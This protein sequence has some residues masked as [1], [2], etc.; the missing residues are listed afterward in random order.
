MSI[1][2]LIFSLI[3]ISIVV[4]KNPIVYEISI[5]PWLYELSIKYGRSITKLEDIPEE[6]I[7]F[8]ADMGVDAVYIMGIWKLGEYGLNY[9]KTL[10][11]DY[12]LP[13]WQEEDI[14]GSPFAITEYVCNPELGTDKDIQVL[15][16]KFNIRQVKLYLDFVPNHSAI[17][18][19]KTSTDEDM[20]IMAP[21]GKENLT[22]RYAEN[23]LAYGADYAH[24]AWVDVNQWNYFE[25]KTIT[26]MMNNL[27]KVLTY[28]DGVVCT[29]AYLEINDVFE[30]TW[31]DELTYF[32]YTKPEEEF[33]TIAI[34]NARKNFK[35]AVFIAEAYT[36]THKEKLLE[37]GFDYVLDADLRSKL[38]YSAN[39]VNTYIQQGSIIPWEKTAHFIENHDTERF[40]SSVDGDYEK[41]K[42]AGTIAASVGGMVFMNH[43]QWYGRK[44]KLDIHLRR[45]AG[46]D[47]NNDMLSYYKQLLPIL[48]NTAFKSPQYNYVETDNSDFVAY[49]REDESTDNHLLVV[50]NYSDTAK[51]GNVPIYNIKGLKYCLLYE[52]FSDEEYVR[53]V[54]LIK[55]NGLQVCLK[56]WETQIFKYNY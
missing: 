45:A 5:R 33:W 28:S 2:K 51:C 21:P 8:I 47:N 12:V 22:N 46:E 4:T 23:G 54:E 40:V 25:P 36:D 53:N 34:N 37:L 39:D 30:K 19:V 11:Y 20:Y 50:V 14:I 41:A 10:D 18:G 35:T 16:W 56:P 9:D 48:T 7:D 24:F 55:K 13:D 3:L 29:R 1:N 17:D 43:G 52:P 6:E 42:A 32:N 31:E 38:L 44:Y 26:Y 49:I 15:R 27:E